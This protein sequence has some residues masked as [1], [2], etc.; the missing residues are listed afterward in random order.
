MATTDYPGR[1]ML[2]GFFTDNGSAGTT[3]QRQ[4]F[5]QDLFDSFDDH[6]VEACAAIVPPLDPSAEIRATIAVM[7]EHAPGNSRKKRAQN[8][9]AAYVTFRGM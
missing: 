9:V 6:I 1:I 4:N 3:Q 5:S 7:A 8:A 2:I